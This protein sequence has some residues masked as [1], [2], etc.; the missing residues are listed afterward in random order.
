MG[1]YDVVRSSTPYDGRLS[2][3]RVDTIRLPNGD[4]VDREVVEHPDAV[5]VVPVDADGQVV[6]VR[7]FRHVLRQPQLEIP[8]GILDVDGEA[9]EDA[10]QRELT[11]EVGLVAG[12]L[13]ELASFANSVGWTDEATTV[14]LGT[15]LT[16]TPL[17]P[18]YSP[19]AE[20]ADMEVVRLPLD[21][22]LR[23]IDDGGLRDAKTVIGLL[24]AARRL[25]TV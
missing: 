14:Y 11:E 2:R 9:P 19:H 3:V 16:S 5:A 1:S 12:T 8:A 23:M 22:A 4:L 21:T 24:L 13:V 18:G 6:L 15:E 7:Q 25:G 20:E 17:P 10:A